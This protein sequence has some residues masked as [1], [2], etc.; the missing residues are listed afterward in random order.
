MKYLCEMMIPN[1]H[2]SN[3]DG[4]KRTLSIDP[5]S[6]FAYYQSAASEISN[7]WEWGKFESKALILKISGR[8][9]Q[10]STFFSMSNDDFSGRDF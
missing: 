1:Q 5:S 10:K 6:F 3:I 4:H 9:N 2:E 8:K 7:D